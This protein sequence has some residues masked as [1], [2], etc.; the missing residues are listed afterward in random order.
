VI[1]IGPNG[2]EID[3]GPVF[4]RDDNGPFEGRAVV[5]V[6]DNGGLVFRRGVGDEVTRIP[7]S[8]C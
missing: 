5:G 7:N 2:I 1:A 6:G 8:S 3:N 4:P